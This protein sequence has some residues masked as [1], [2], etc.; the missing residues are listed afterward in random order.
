VNHHWRRIS[1]DSQLHHTHHH[2]TTNQEIK[3]T[4][5]PRLSLIPSLANCCY[6]YILVNSRFF[7]Q[8]RPV[9]CIG[10]ASVAFI[11]SHYVSSD[12]SRV[13]V[14]LTPLPISI[15]TSNITSAP[16]TGKSIFFT[17]LDALLPRKSKFF[18]IYLYRVLSRQTHACRGMRRRD[19]KTFAIFLRTQHR[20]MIKKRRFCNTNRCSG[21]T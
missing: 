3:S 20:L 5:D 13:R 6:N 11:N 2:N 9:W 21:S 7:Y 12:E 16:G 1:L 19:A 17:F 10:L 18:C 15:R 4:T 8:Q 14:S